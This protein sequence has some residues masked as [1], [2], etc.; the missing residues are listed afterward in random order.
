MGALV[1]PTEQKPIMACF[2]GFANDEEWYGAKR[3]GAVNVG[4]D[5]DMGWR[6]EICK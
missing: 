3:G 5:T 2:R 1:M 4:G 6:V